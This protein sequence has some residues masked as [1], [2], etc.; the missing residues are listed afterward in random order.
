MSNIV[1]V[2]CI[3]MGVFTAIFLT[4]ILIDYVRIKKRKASFLWEN[5]NGITYSVVRNS[6]GYRLIYM[7]G[8]TFEKAKE[9]QQSLNFYTT[10]EKDE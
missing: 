6:N 9:I 1:L 10:I 7:S 4:I 3:L 2:C 8:L 5:K